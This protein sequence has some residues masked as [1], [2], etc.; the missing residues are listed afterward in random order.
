L[1]NEIGGQRDLMRSETEKGTVAVVV[2]AGVEVEEDMR[3]AVAVASMA[4][5]GADTKTAI[6]GVTMAL[7]VDEVGAHEV[8]A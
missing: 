4:L 5:P 7:A 6:E 3:V 1:K 8:A 2:E